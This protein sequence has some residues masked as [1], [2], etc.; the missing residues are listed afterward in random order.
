[1]WKKSWIFFLHKKHEREKTW[2]KWINNEWYYDVDD[3]GHISD[4]IAQRIMCSLITMAC[5]KSMKYVMIKLHSLN[6]IW[7]TQTETMSFFMKSMKR[8]VGVK[9]KKK[10]WNKKGVKSC[11]LRKRTINFNHVFEKFGCVGNIIGEEKKRHNDDES[12]TL[13]Y[14]YSFFEFDAIYFSSI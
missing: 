13:T 2:I 7:R 11:K 12:E 9:W 3:D 4:W 5:R 8:N 6:A 14:V 10:C 1:M